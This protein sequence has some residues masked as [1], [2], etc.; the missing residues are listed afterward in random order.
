MET[1]TLNGGG[2][3]DGE[4]HRKWRGGGREPVQKGEAGRKTLGASELAW[5]WAIGNA[6]SDGPE[7]GEWGD[8]SPQT[9]H[10]RYL[11]ACELN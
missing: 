10:V 9:T 8:V 1:K 3:A 2:R 4:A 7:S 6:H 11:G 5:G